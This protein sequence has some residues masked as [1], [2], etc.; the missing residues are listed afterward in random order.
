[1]STVDSPIKVSHKTKE[2]I[3]LAAAVSNITHAELVEKA[4]EEFLRNHN[5]E[6]EEGLAHTKK[7]LLL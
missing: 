5:K 6:I 2:N 1:M 7:L 4:V 3:R